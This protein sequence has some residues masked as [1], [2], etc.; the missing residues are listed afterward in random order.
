MVQSSTAGGKA[1]QK[2]GSGAGRR[3]RAAETAL[4]E[5]LEQLCQP[6]R[7]RDYPRSLATMRA[8]LRAL[9]EPQG[10]LRS[11]VVTGS[12]GKSSVSR[13]LAGLLQARGL[14]CGCYISPHLHSFRE[15]FWLNGARIARADF[16]AGAAE[17]AAAAAGLGGPVSTFERATALALWW[18]RQQGA[19][20][21]V[22]ETG[23][24]GRF[25]AVNVTRPALALFT[26][27]EAE[28]TALLGGDLA[29]V[30]WHKAGVVPARGRALSAAQV[31]AVRAI[32]QEECARRGAQVRFTG[33]GLARAAVKALVAGGVVAD[34]A[35]DV[36]P[37]A[38]PG[39]LEVV[40]MAEGPALLIDGGHTAAAAKVLR[41]EIEER[42]GAEGS[43]ALVAGLLADKDA[44]AWLRVF[45]E[46]R[47]HITLT[48]APG[49]RAAAPRKLAARS[50]LRRARV[51]LEADFGRALQ[52]ARES[53]AAL[54]VVGGSL[55]LAARAREL[56]GLLSA[57]E[58]AEAR[59]TARV[60]SGGA[61][62]ARLPD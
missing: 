40:R 62:L 26:G 4:Q 57:E 47:F 24:G 54:V 23:V 50:R 15:R 16:C 22:L 12:S 46:A 37:V 60:F 28:H 58:L 39:R 1:Q 48:R 17:V 10:G 45:D 20:L 43:V 9:G 21:A 35:V 33:E 56:A 6:V 36:K 41:A 34:A 7:R 25:D 38:L 51:R 8:L 27:I 52:A 31:P 3:G 49:H 29:G 59:L 2:A 11:V 42:V 5:A 55:R 19:E 14:R 61:Y 30:A 32:L 44:A 53:E 18:F 13:Q